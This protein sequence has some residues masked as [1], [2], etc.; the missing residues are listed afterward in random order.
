MAV[1]AFTVANIKPSLNIDNSQRFI[2]GLEGSPEPLGSL[3]LDNIFVPVN[4]VSAQ[5]NFELRNNTLSGFR[6]IH[7]TSNSDNIGS[8]ALQSFVNAESN[9]IDILEV[10]N[11][12]NV[13]FYTPVSISSDFDMQSYKITN[14]G[15]PIVDTDASTKGYVDTSISDAIGSISTP[16][17]TL[18][19]DVTGSGNISS[20]ITT[21]LTTTLDAVSAPVT[22]VDLN[23]YKIINLANGININDAV[24]LSQIKFCSRT[25]S[26]KN[27]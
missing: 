11:D 1:S 18:E 8:L 20:P 5:T 23:S 21:T 10:N 26:I 12:N 9:G 2:F 3:K 14:L 19:G 27:W 7:K 16:T 25:S 24:N 17:I 13:I 4:R 22:D 6:W 15:T